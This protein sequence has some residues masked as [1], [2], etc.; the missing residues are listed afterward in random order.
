MRLIF[1]VSA[2]LMLITVPAQAYVGPGLGLGAIGVILGLLLSVVLAFFA[3]VW[4][5][6]KRM[7]KRKK[8]HVEDAADE[9]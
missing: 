7:F 9:G 5:P 6:I 4:M 1:P 2:M 8:A 3:F